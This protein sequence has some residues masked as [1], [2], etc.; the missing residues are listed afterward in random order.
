MSDFQPQLTTERK[1]LRRELLPGIDTDSHSQ[2]PPV[3]V[4]FAPSALALMSS[5]TFGRNSSYLGRWSV[6]A[7][8]PRTSSSSKAERDSIDC[9]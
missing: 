1:Q 2:P 8:P 4:A 3:I 7:S 5:T 6:A 9:T